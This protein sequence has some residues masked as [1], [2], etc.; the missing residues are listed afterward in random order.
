MI[1]LL[2]R[3][4][5]RLVLSSEF[6]HSLRGEAFPRHQA[7]SRSDRRIPPGSFGS[8]SPVGSRW[9][10][11]SPAS[12]RGVGE[13]Q[14]DLVV[15]LARDYG[16]SLPTSEDVLLLIEIADTSLVSDREVKLP[17]YAEEYS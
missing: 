16:D 7:V 1:C 2:P 3:R 11:G 9:A 17:L 4:V 6:V 15:I 5:F 14:P 10:A 12:R 8:R 13:R